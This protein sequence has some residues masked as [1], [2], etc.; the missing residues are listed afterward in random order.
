MFYAT[1]FNFINYKFLDNVCIE[2]DAMFYRTQILCTPFNFITSMWI[3]VLNSTLCSTRH[4]YLREKQFMLRIY[5]WIALCQ[6]KRLKGWPWTWTSQF[7]W[8]VGAIWVQILGEVYL[9]CHQLENSTSFSGY[10]VSYNISFDIRIFKCF[11]V[12][13][14]ISYIFS[15][16]YF[17]AECIAMY[18]LL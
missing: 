3:T 10:S 1:P 5:T 8:T 17:S 15:V 7:G 12:F 14:F 2:V 9:C 11:T 4:R 6:A 16:F 13:E 18:F